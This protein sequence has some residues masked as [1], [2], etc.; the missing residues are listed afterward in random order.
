M[1]GGGA[2]VNL[3]AMISSMN[4]DEMLDAMDLIWSKLLLDP[5]RLDSPQWHERIV[6][7]RLADPSGDPLPLKEAEADVRNR[8]NEGRTQ[9]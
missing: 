9:G 8:R 3:E 1:V 2:K 7:E 4:R 6:K 5:E